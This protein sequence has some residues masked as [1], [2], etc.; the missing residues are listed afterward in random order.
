MSLDRVFIRAYAKGE[1]VPVSAAD[2]SCAN[3]T[4]QAPGHTTR[5]GQFGESAPPG[6]FKDIQ[7][8]DSSHAG[9]FAP[10]SARFVPLAGVP[11]NDALAL[12]SRSDNSGGATDG[13]EPPVE[14]DPSVRPNAVP[15]SSVASWQTEVAPWEAA[16]QVDKFH[17]PAVCDRLQRRMSAQLD[18]VAEHLRVLAHQGRRVMAVCSARRGEGR[19]TLSLA[20][21]RQLAQDGTEVVLVDADF[22]QPSLSAR[23]G[24]S[25]TVTSS[26]L[27]SGSAP[28]AETLVESLADRLT[29]LPSMAGMSDLEPAAA[30]TWETALSELRRRYNCVV[31]D[32]P[33]VAESMSRGRTR[34]PGWWLQV[35]AAL[36]VHDMRSSEPAGDQTA[37]WLRS[38]GVEPWGVIENFAA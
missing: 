38:A 23:L 22:T 5:S 25:P 9:V 27:L 17:W 1:P 12:S 34:L 26:D 7:R 15:L 30:A 18:H 29:L 4:P 2:R 11:A 35:D 20:L 24:L 33:P 31:L 21:A 28:L 8:V 10:A 13:R 14:S 16:W 37:S 3:A 36:V 6:R 32:V 19:S